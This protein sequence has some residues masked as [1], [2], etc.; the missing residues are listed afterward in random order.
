[1]TE[2]QKLLLQIEIQ[3]PCVHL[4]NVWKNND[5]LSFMLTCTNKM[6]SSNYSW[7]SLKIIW[8]HRWISYNLHIHTHMHL[9]ACIYTHMHKLHENMNSF[10]IEVN[11]IRLQC[12]GPCFCWE[13]SS[14][15]FE[16][17]Y[18]PEK[19]GSALIICEFVNRGINLLSTKWGFCWSQSKLIIPKSST[20]AGKNV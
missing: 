1:M 18:F 13:L 7:F 10:T 9:C 17:L 20:S 15:W 11:S 16:N 5:K 19:K 12:L 6:C 4:F 2:S 3:K 14:Y 8:G